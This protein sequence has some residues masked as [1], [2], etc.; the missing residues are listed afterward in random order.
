MFQIIIHRVHIRDEQKNS[1]KSGGIIA[2][3][4]DIVGL[5]LVLFA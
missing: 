4:L 5:S 2:W 1:Y 3:D